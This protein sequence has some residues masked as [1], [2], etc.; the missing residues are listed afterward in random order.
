MIN[1]GNINHFAVP[2]LLIALVCAF[3]RTLP[4]FGACP[5]ESLLISAVRGL[6]AQ[7]HLQDFNPASA[8]DMISGWL[9][10]LGG[11]SLLGW[12]LWA[13][14]FFGW[15]F[16]FFAVLLALTVFLELLPDKRVRAILFGTTLVLFF[17]VSI[18]PAWQGIF[19]R[20]RR[21]SNLELVAPAALCRLA[22][23]QAEVFTSP[24][25]LPY[26]LLFAPEIGRKLS[27]S[28]SVV[29]SKNPAAWREAQRKNH[30]STVVLSG[31][32]DEYKP[33]LDHLLASPDW[34]L[35]AIDNF[36]Y[37]FR[38]GA[39][40]PVTLPDFHS[41]HLAS[42]QDTA[43]YLAQIAGYLDAIRKTGDARTC[44]ERALQLSPQDLTVLA[45]AA[46]FSIERKRWQDA[47]AYCDRV[48]EINPDHAQAKI[49]KA[50]ALMQL[51]EW[52]K[53]YGLLNEVLIQIPDDVYTLFLQARVCRSLHDYAAESQMLERLLRLPN[54]TPEAIAYYHLYLGQAYAK[55]GFPDPALKNYKIAVDSGHLSQEQLTDV[56]DQMKT[57]EAKKFP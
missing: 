21:I 53:A 41:F 22:K 52:Q 45:H 23:E 36:G 25:A 27:P 57:I 16:A 24:T 34:H 44:M 4:L 39:A 51:N 13:M 32:S 19:Q 30:W 14:S 31:R 42:N 50:L 6:A 55:Q 49:V 11:T 48:L 38:N 3:L 54:Q 46:S 10:H 12:G 47:I 5:D 20:S 18:P 33:L 9:W 56:R 28:D 7:W 1:R 17:A 2:A 37:L 8:Q 26:C 40:P 43:I 29:L 35:A 15:T